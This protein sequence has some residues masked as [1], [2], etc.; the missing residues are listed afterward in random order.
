MSGT[1]EMSVKITPDLIRLSALILILPIT[2]FSVVTMMNPDL[3]K[4]LAHG[5]IQDGHK[6]IQCSGCHQRDNATWRQ[7]IQANV[8]F[9]L[10]YRDDAVDFGYLPV[11]STQCLNCHQRP[12]ERHP[13][14]R[15]R[16][17]RFADAVE[18][19]MA[20]SCLGC[21]TE[22]T[23]E[24]SFAPVEFCSACHKDLKLTSDPL[25]VPHA[26]LAKDQRWGTC[27]GC[28]DFHGN[29]KKRAPKL[30]IEAAPILEIIEYLADGSSPYG[31]EKVYKADIE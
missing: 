4:T 25:D 9:A 3:K 6:D 10:G 27:L 7:Q 29:H 13:I 22:H 31:A 19:V 2:L 18:K 30:L 12:N 28:H 8:Q 23:D 16:E 17:P 26:T 15:F 20:T 24:R 1:G 21:H 14:Y 11:T 5:P